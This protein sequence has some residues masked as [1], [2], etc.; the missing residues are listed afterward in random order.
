MPK[1]AEK[2]KKEK[3]SWEALLPPGLGAILSDPTTMR[4]ARCAGLME[5]NRDADS[6]ECGSC[7]STETMPT[8]KTRLPFLR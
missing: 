6:Y 1:K 5:F 4:C 2:R 8:K 3:T 7:G